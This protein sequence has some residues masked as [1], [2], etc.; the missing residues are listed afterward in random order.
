MKNKNKQFWYSMLKM[1]KK[2]KFLNTIT[3]KCGNKNVFLQDQLDISTH[4][5]REVHLLN[6][7]FNTN[8]QKKKTIPAL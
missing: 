2:W 4:K 3:A 8:K 6:N 1:L 7:T 5:C